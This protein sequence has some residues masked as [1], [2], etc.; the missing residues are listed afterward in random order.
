MA[1]KKFYG[2]KNKGR[3]QWNQSQGPP[4]KEKEKKGKKENHICRG[5]QR[6]WMAEELG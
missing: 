4:E 6:P 1:S 2:E 3:G 5:I